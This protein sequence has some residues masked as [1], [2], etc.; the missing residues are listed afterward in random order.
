MTTTGRRRVVITGMATLNPLGDTLEEYYGNLIAGK[1]G[2]RPWK[3]IDLSRVENKVGGDLGDYDFD[4][5]L[6]RLEP[7]LGPQLFKR[8]RK[9]FRHATFSSKTGCYCALWAYLD[10]GLLGAGVDPYRVSCLVAGHNLNSRHNLENGLRFM[11]EPDTIDPLIA[12][13][14]ID[15]NSP[16]LISELLGIKGP[17]FTLGAACA[18]GNIALRDGMRDI[19]T[20][21]CDWSVVTGPAFDVSPADIHA[22]V[23]VDSVVTNKE[24]QKTPSSASRPFDKRRNGFVYS[25][26][27]ATLV[28]EELGKA[29][30]RGARI[31]AELL[32]VKASSDAYHV[33]APD[34][35][36]QGRA[37]REAMA[38]AGVRPDEIDY[39]NCHATGTPLGDREEIKAI[40]AALGEHAYRVKVNAPKS[41]LGHT[42]WASPL[43]ETIGGILQ[44]R[45][46]MLHPTI[47]IEELDPEI[48]LDVCPNTA[49]AYDARVM[50]KNSFG[51]GGLNCVSVI[52][53][54]DESSIGGDR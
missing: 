4:A 17:T 24:L 10:A 48:D 13:E 18:S 27:A 19:Q 32:A 39:V 20:D 28:L 52:R 54:W 6:R 44:M 41:M 30:A 37:M 53:R 3:S 2:I 33:P 14:G 38:T 46:G 7:R 50:L 31:Y 47:N 43:V 26:G 34:S 42:C 9:V 12:V 15:P 40:K 8:V 23:W 1:S 51:F 16:A 29:R 36:E 49:V 21:E 22:S 5:A 35:G 45:N 25:H 11:K